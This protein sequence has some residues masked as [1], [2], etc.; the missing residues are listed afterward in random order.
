METKRRSKQSPTTDQG[1][2]QQQQQ[3]QQQAN[4]TQKKCSN[5]KTKVASFFCLN[6]LF[7]CEECNNQ[8]HSFPIFQTHVRNK[9][10]KKDLKNI[11]IRKR[12]QPV[13]IAETIG[14]NEGKKTPNEED[15]E[16]KEK[17]KEKEKEKYNEPVVEEQLKK[18]IKRLDKN[19]K[20][21]HPGFETNIL[22]I[23]NEFK[24]DEKKSNIL[25]LYIK[26]KTKQVKEKTKQETEKTKRLKVTEKTKQETEKTKQL[27][28]QFEQEKNMQPTTSNSEFAKKNKRKKNVIQLTETPFNYGNISKDDI[29]DMMKKI[30]KVQRKY[31][32]TLYKTINL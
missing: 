28:I 17:E 26:E 5:C 25:K 32:E 10:K 31:L 27:Q 16:H 15:D 21:T 9:L 2:K 23:I 7:L 20:N 8:I 11:N 14:K 1:L 18:K 13:K 4:S 12:K 19:L 6:C 3:Q 29:K 30:K 22:K 24:D